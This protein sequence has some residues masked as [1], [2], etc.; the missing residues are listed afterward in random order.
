MV[1]IYSNYSTAGHE[2]PRNFVICPMAEN[3][4]QAR[5]YNTGPSQDL[6]LSTLPCQYLT[7]LGR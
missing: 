3:R 6:F 4:R 1:S 5:F 2:L 7:T